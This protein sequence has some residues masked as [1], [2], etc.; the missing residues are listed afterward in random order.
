MQARK[1]SG[2]IGLQSTK[3]VLRKTVSDANEVAEHARVSTFTGL[4]RIS[5]GII[6]VDAD[7]KALIADAKAVTESNY[8]LQLKKQKLVKKKSKVKFH[9]NTKEAAADA[10]NIFKQMEKQNTLANIEDGMAENRMK[11]KS[12]SMKRK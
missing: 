10:R 9:V 6:T 2:F 4:K 8:A 11:R 7:E 3:N 1:V 12:K 5:M